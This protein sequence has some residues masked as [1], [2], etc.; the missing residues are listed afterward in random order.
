MVCGPMALS[1]SLRPSVPTAF[2]IHRCHIQMAPI[3]LLVLF[4]CKVAALKSQYWC[5]KRF[6]YS[7]SSSITTLCRRGNRNPK[8][9]N[10]M[11]K[12]THLLG[13]KLRQECFSWISAWCSFW[14]TRIS[15]FSGK[16]VAQ[17]VESDDPKSKTDLCYLIA[18]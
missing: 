4:L 10:I 18:I 17:H 8:R 9:G 13:V 1:A 11:V 15:D 16:H 3:I 7:S 5:W 6:Y 14:F 2:A 12:T